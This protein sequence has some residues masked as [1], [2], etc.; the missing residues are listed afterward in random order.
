MALIE[1][2]YND[3]VKE[4]GLAK[5]AALAESF[6]HLKEIINSGYDDI[7]AKALEAFN[8]GQITA[9]QYN[10]L[11]KRL[12]DI[13]NL[14]GE[15]DW[16]KMSPP[17]FDWDFQIPRFA[18]GTTYVDKGN[19]YPTGTDTVPAYLNKGER[20]IPTNLNKQL[21]GISNADLIRIIQ[22][23][24]L[25]RNGT[26]IATAAGMV[27]LAS[28]ASVAAASSYGSTMDTAKLEALIAQMSAEIASQSSYLA[29]IAAKDPS[30]DFHRLKSAFQQD[31]A[32]TDRTSF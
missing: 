12:F 14:I 25:Y 26:N 24:N 21:G 23:S 31:A 20:V 30:I 3:K 11:A 2:T 7:I 6:K 4:L 1:Q 16:S 27:N 17:D 22:N 13:K 29:A 32:L 8:Q 5:D 18:E 28:P 15:I 9:D 10:E 19:K